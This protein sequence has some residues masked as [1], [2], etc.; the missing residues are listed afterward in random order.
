[1]EQYK[2]FIITALLTTLALSQSNAQTYHVTY[3]ESIIIDTFAI[4]DLPKQIRDHKLQL[5]KIKKP[6][7]L[8]YSKGISIYS[9]IDKSDR[10]KYYFKNMSTNSMVFELYAGSEKLCGKDSLIEMNW[11]I[12][13]ETKDIA[14]YKSQKAISR[15]HN[16]L[17]TAW[18]TNEIPINAGPERFDGLPGL[19]L[20]VE[21]GSTI[22]EFKD[23]VIREASFEISP[24]QQSP[25]TMTII[26]AHNYIMEQIPKYKN[27]GGGTLI[28]KP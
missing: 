24:P 17:F 8:T 22:F 5:A 12:S 28:R 6:Y 27:I 13:N 25:P 26:E 15:W 10:P 2:I 20:R 9:E 19:I 7:N 11:E 16:Y 4:K 21:I 14:G 23:L 18:F 3:T 1:M